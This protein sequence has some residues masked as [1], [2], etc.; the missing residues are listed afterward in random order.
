MFAG[1]NGS[2]KSTLKAYLPPALL[3]VYLNAD[4]IEPGIHRQGFL[5]FST[6]GVASTAEEVLPF[7]TSSEFLRSANLSAAAGEMAFA[8]GRLVFGPAAVN[9]YLALVA[10]D[11]LRQKLLMQRVRAVCGMTLV[12]I[13]FICRLGSQRR[14]PS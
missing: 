2:G 10:A 4:E 6:Y 13:R 9:S 11:F 8:E 12:A 3:G 5:D 7:F 14:S 1:P